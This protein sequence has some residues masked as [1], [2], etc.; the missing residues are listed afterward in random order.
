MMILFMTK[1]VLVLSVIV[2]NLYL[3]ITYLLLDVHSH[4]TTRRT[5]REELLSSIHLL[6]LEKRKVR[7]DNESCVSAVSSNMIEK[8]G[9][10][11]EPH[12]HPY[13][14]SWINSMTQD[15]KQ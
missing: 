4:N 3:Q 11:V 14:V 8:V 13:K 15:V 10:K 12:P 7:V 1:N 9:L 6:R 5:V 2:L